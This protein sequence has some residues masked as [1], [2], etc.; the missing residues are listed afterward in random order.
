MGKYLRDASLSFAAARFA[1]G[2]SL[3]YVFFASASLTR[4]S[5]SRI[6]MPNLSLVTISAIFLLRRS[7][8]GA[9]GTLQGGYDY[10]FT[11]VLCFLRVCGVIVIDGT[12]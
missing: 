10:P 3:P 11:D 8:S 9:N 2:D 4:G 6:A 12:C 7:V 5:S 1:A